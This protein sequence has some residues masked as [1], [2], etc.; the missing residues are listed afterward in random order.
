MT[1][2]R[3]FNIYVSSEVFWDESFFVDIGLVLKK[4][5]LRIFVLLQNVSKRT[6]LISIK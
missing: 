3:L 1:T 2:F 4:I 6:K 5:A